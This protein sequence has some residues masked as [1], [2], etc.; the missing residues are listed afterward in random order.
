MRKRSLVSI[1]LLALMTMCSASSAYGADSNHVSHVRSGHAWILQL[2]DD[3][4][5]RSATLRVLLDHIEESDG[6]VYVELGTCPMVGMKACLPNWMAHSKTMRFLRI[7]LDPDVPHNDA[8]IALL[9]HELR[10]VA[11]VLDDKSVTNGYGM[12]QLF[13]R[14]GL[15][16]GPRSFETA[17]AQRAGFTVARELSAT[18][19]ITRDDD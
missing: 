10:H 3:G 14:I 16:S 18:A 4:R 9:A 7:L 1:C 12:V 8:T 15:P 2:L 11:E 17:E 19:I 6:I 5:N 13:K